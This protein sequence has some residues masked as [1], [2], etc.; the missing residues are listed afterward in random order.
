MTEKTGMTK[1]EIEADNF[2]FYKKFAPWISD[3]CAWNWAKSPL[4][5]K[6]GL[7]VP[8]K[9]GLLYIATDINRLGEYKI[10]RT[11]HNDPFKRELHTTSPYYK[12]LYMA[13]SRDIVNEEMKIHKWCK[14]FLGAHLKFDHAKE[15]FKLDDDYLQF[16]IDKFHFVKAEH[17]MTQ[18]RWIKYYDPDETAASISPEYT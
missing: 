12:V 6:N 17:P 11:F 16:V 7:A 8:D 10:G 9:L 5:D 3:E 18:L 15:W 1:E 13:V 14:K 4:R 2:R